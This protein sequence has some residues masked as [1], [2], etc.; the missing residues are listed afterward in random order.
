MQ[1]EHA[2]CASLPGDAAGAAVWRDRARNHAAVENLGEAERCL[3]RA[4]ELSSGLAHAVAS[5]ARGG[6]Y[7]GQRRWAAAI[8]AFAESLRT[9]FDVDT[10]VAL[11]ICY[12][13]LG[14]FAPAIRVFRQALAVAP[15]HT[16][17]RTGLAAAEQCLQAP[18][19]AAPQA[20][21]VVDEFHHAWY[22]TSRWGTIEWLGVPM[23]KNPFDLVQYQ[24]ILWQQRPDFVIECGAFLGGSTLY[25]A[26]LLDLIGHGTVLSVELEDSWMPAARHHP[27]VVTIAGD[28]VGPETLRAVRDRVPIGASCFVILD[29]D[30][31]A[32]HVLAE[33]RAYERFVR[34]GNYLIVEDS[35]LNG[36]PILPGWGP[37]PWEAVE[38]FL[39]ENSHFVPD[40]AREQKLLL[41]FAPFG[42]LKRVSDVPS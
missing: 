8:P 11:G 5:C 14:A 25:F 38:T 35:N 15:A 16:G 26:H 41:T 4:E 33:L 29:S 40:R 20:S 12:F 7:V 1:A 36:H 3:I 22:A 9:A 2:V 28:S 21:P 23:S 30:H 13:E 17:A 24:E 19:A 39:G 37:G 32:E 42:W 6:L 27:R 34:P 10:L 31:R 18:P